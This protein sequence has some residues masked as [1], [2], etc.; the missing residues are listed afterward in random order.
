MGKERQF[1][2]PAA[3]Y[4][5]SMALQRKLR[6]QVV[7]VTG[8]SSGIG[9]ATA[10]E[11]ARRGARV[12]LAA[13]RKGALSA[14]A[15]EC[16][17]LGAEALVVPTDVTDPAAV[18]RLASRAVSHFGRIDA[19]VNNAA[20]AT[21]GTLTEVPPEEFRRVIEVNLL[22][23]AYGMRSALGH[24]RAAGGGVIVNNASVLA[25]IA[26]PYLTSYNAAKHGV[27]GL[28]DTVRQELRV[29]GERTI[30][31]CT[32]LPATID[33][34]FFAHAAN[35]TGRALAPPPPIY[36][37]QLVARTIVG[38]IR[39]PRREA[40]AGG[41]ARLLSLQWRLLPG[42]AERMMAGYAEHALFRSRP[43]ASTTGN[44][45]GQEADEARIAGGWHGRARSALR[46][47]AAFGIAAGAAAV[48][49]RRH[50]QANR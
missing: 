28:S 16:R 49:A 47:S 44:V 21:Y 27:R 11:L 48:L 34:P 46:T 50:A 39:R 3:G 7:V 10:L 33:T 5:A 14:V 24:L 38:M 8:A 32:V 43:A 23:V 17:A 31:V 36:P 26:M 9:A 41:A 45:F 29:N 13:R 15:D 25:E 22:G 18:D 40:Y 20:V 35:H 2:Y 37:A 12:V 4:P 1:Y 19:W 30:S 6:D 42:A